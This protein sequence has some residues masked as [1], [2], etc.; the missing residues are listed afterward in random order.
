MT[1]ADVV[2]LLA[3]GQ[4]TAADHVLDLGA[5]QLRDLVHDLAEDE[6]G[7]VVGADVD[8]GSL[9]SAADRGAAVGD[10]HGFCHGVECIPV[11]RPA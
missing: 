2:S 11:G 10:D 6:G 5:V 9:A 8:E 1:T 4:T 7:E 3:A